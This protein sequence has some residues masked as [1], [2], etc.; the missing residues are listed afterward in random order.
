MVLLIMA[1]AAVFVLAFRV[2]P[3]IVQGHGN[4]YHDMHWIVYGY[5]EVWYHGRNYI[6]PRNTACRAYSP[7]TSTNTWLI[8]M[9]MLKPAPALH[10]LTPTLVILQKTPARCVVYTLSGGP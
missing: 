6:Y 8:G 7:L 10:G 5:D 9:R 3:V 1:A 4:L 2:V